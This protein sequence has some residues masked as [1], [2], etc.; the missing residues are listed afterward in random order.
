[1]IRYYSTNLFRTAMPVP[2][3]PA[4]DSYPRQTDNSKGR[5]DI[6]SSRASALDDG[7]SVPLLHAF[8][9]TDA[10]WTQTLDALLRVGPEDDGQWYLG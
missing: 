6:D 1:M 10:V 4:A 9:I 7:G 5:V 3:T 2:G 8:D